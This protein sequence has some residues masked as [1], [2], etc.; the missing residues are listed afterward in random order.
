MATDSTILLSWLMTLE[1][2]ITSLAKTLSREEPYRPSLGHMLIPGPIIIP[3]MVGVLWLV[4]HG[5]HTCLCRIHDSPT[6]TTW[7][8]GEAILLRKVT[9]YIRITDIHYCFCPELSPPFLVLRTK[10]DLGDKDAKLEKKNIRKILFL[11]VDT[12]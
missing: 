7:C 6:I 2:K 5:S 4:C 8:R 11:P 10:F 1:G 9:A 3:V 12:I